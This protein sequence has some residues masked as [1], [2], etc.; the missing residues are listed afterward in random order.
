VSANRYGID[1]YQG[2]CAAEGSGGEEEE[3]R[4]SPKPPMITTT[5]KKKKSY[6]LCFS[7]RRNSCPI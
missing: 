3:N 7:L 1:G 5:N 6:Q 2:I 4:F